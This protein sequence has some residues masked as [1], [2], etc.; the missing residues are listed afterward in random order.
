M[1]ARILDGFTDPMLAFVYDRVNTRFGKLRVLLIS[2]LLYTSWMFL[3]NCITVVTINKGVTPNDQRREQLALFQDIFF[4]LLE[5][6]IGQ[7]G[8]L[9]L[10]LRVDVYKRQL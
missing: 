2:C 4:K 1:L 6:I 10:K 3:K 7:R 8:N 5:F 9:G